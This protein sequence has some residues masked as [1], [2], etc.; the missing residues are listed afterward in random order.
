MQFF[1]IPHGNYNLPFPITNRDQLKFLCIVQ[2]EILKIKKRSKTTI[3]HVNNG[4]RT[5]SN[6]QNEIYSA[7]Q[8]VC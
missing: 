2:I 8:V 1:V 5:V 4:K 3:S 6:A 7:Q